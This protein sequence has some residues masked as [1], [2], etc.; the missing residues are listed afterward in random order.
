MLIVK[1]ESLV[2]LNQDGGKMDK[3]WC[4]FNSDYEGDF[5]LRICSTKKLADDYVKDLVERELYNESDL[6]LEEWSIDD[7]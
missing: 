5:L 4:V 2:S 3:V 1:L 7:K 6:L